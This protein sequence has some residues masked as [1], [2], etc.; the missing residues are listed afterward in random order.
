MNILSLDIGTKRTGLAFANTDVQVPL[1]LATL[2][3]DSS[4]IWL[5]AILHIIQTKHITTVVVG[6]PLLPSGEVGSQAKFVQKRIQQLQVLLPTTVTVE[7][8]DER[9]TSFHELE[10]DQDAASATKIL[11]IW[12]DKNN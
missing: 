8:I 7:F 1:A 9:Y 4:T 5:E 10:L 12:L 6:L 3:Q 2:V 11:Q